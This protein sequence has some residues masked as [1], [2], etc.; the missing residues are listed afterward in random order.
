MIGIVF[1]EWQMRAERDRLFKKKAGRNTQEFPTNAWRGKTSVKVGRIVNTYTIMF[2]V[3]WYQAA[4]TSCTQLCA[5]RPQN[6]QEGHK[7]VCNPFSIACS[8][9][10]WREEVAVRNDMGLRHNVR[11]E[12]LMQFWTSFEFWLKT[13]LLQLKTFGLQ[14]AYFALRRWGRDRITE[15]GRAQTPKWSQTTWRQEKFV[16]FGISKGTV[17]GR[18]DI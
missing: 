1:S 15:G 13:Q 18:G 2:Y 16:A 4:A 6:V 5:R 10:I 8:S 9:V 12:R 14:K 11:Q 3:K 7:N 17:R